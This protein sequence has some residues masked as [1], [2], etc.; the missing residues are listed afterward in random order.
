MNTAIVLLNEV[1]KLEE[2]VKITERCPV[3][4]YATDSNPEDESVVNAKGMLGLLSINVKEPIT[5]FT[6]KVDED[7]E[8]YFD[9]IAKFIV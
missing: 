6:K 9:S 8:R 3:A 5:I 4:V 1:S 2:F 7:S